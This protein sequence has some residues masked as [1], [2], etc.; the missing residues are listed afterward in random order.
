MVIKFV[1]CRVRT[2]EHLCWH[3]NRL[4]A[5]GATVI[6]DC[7]KSYGPLGND[8]RPDL[9]KLDCDH[10]KG[11]SSPGPNSTAKGLTSVSTNAVEG[12]GHGTLYKMVRMWLG[13]K[14]GKGSDEHE[15]LVKD[16]ALAI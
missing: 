8:I 2:K 9:N 11:F 4:M 6:T 1:V 7:H 10:S 13:C 3:M 15:A 5:Q 12:G 14:I 16:L